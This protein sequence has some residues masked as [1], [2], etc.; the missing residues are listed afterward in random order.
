MDDKNID[1]IKFSYL[2]D[3]DKKEWLSFINFLYALPE[4]SELKK[5]AE[6]FIENIRSDQIYFYLLSLYGIIILIKLFKSINYETLDVKFFEKM[7]KFNE[8]AK[9][10]PIIEEMIKQKIKD[11][12]FTYLE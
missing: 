6:A 3:E 2:D 5:P 8:C 1:F 4:D 7:Q 11:F 12:A 10:D 9:N